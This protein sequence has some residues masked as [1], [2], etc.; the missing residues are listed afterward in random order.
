MTKWISFYNCIPLGK[1]WS[2]YVKKMEETDLNQ[3]QNQ[4]Y[5]LRNIYIQCIDIFCWKSSKIK[6]K[7]DKTTMSVYVAC[8]KMQLIVAIKFYI[9]NPG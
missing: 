3:N 2:K 9:R 8:A 4:K 6:Q 7:T 1:H 5:N